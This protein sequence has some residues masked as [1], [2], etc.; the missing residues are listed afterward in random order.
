VKGKGKDENGDFKVKGKVHSDGT[1][2]FKKEYSGGRHK[3]E[4]EGRINEAGDA[5]KGD[6]SESGSSGIFEI[7]V[8]YIVYMIRFIKSYSTYH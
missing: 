5:I 7:S 8:R 1:V 3:V 4:Y 6:W 2:S